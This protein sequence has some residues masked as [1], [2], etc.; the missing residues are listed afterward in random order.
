MASEPLGCDASCCLARCVCAEGERRA[1]FDIS[2]ALAAGYCLLL[3]EFGLFLCY[4]LLLAQLLA[5]DV[6]ALKDT[7]C[8]TGRVVI[9]VTI[10][11]GFRKRVGK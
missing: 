6:L 11:Q 2:R 8:A 7:P 3:L 10:V 9:V 4:S 5:V 1:H